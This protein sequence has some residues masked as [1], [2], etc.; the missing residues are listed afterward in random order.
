M[1][2]K[3]AIVRFLKDW[4]LPVGMGTGITVYLLFALTPALDGAATFFAPF[5]DKIVPNNR[6]Q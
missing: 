2:K 3:D 4:S 5:F 6:C 1:K